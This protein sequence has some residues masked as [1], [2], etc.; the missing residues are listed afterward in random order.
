MHKFM[1]VWVVMGIGACAG[2]AGAET[3]DPHGMLPAGTSIRLP[4]NHPGL[5]VDLAVGLW[6]MPLPM[7]YDKDGDYD[8]V[9]ATVNKPSHGV[10]F[11]ENTQGN[12]PFPV[13]E[14]A[15]RVS[16]AVR[17]MTIS[18]VDGDPV[19][20]VPG[21]AF[22]DFRARQLEHKVELATPGPEVEGNVRAR[23]WK[24][25]DYDG[26]GLLD[27]VVGLGIWAE[28]GWDDAY[29]E[30]GE[31]TNGPLRGHVY[32]CRNTGTNDAPVYA[33]P[34]QVMAG[35]GPVD[36]F[37]APS[38][39]FADF[40]GDGD[41]DL[42]CGEFVDRLTY[43]ENVG[44][45]TEPRYAPG[46]YLQ[47]EGRDIHMDLCMLQVIALD[48][49]KNGH[50]DLIVGEEDGR[51]AWLEHTGAVTD[52]M[53]QFLPPRYFKQKADLLKVGVLN[54]PYSCDWDG[55]GDED[56]IVG[57]TAGYVS[58]VENL[59]GGNP[60]RWAAPVRLTAGGET[61]RIQAGYNG[62]IQGPAEAKWGYTV[63]NVA[64]WNHDGLLDIVINSIWGE[65]LWY[66]NEGAPGA[67]K[68][69]GAQPIAVAWDG[70]APKPEWNWWDPKGNQL[71]T[72]WRTSPVVFDWNGDGLYDLIMLDHE[73][74]LAFFERRRD[75]DDLVLLP[76][77]R[78]FLDEQGEPLH[79]NPGR[80]GK[81]G[82]RKFVLADWDGDGAIDILING[83]SINFMRNIGSMDAPRFTDLGS[84][85]ARP[86]GGHTTCPTTVDWDNDGVPDLLYG[87]EDGF[88]YYLK[89]PRGAL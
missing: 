64:D 72:Q 78:I 63:P 23:Q 86:I 57:D 75:G 47:H 81:S 54:T 46:R 45:R 71:V 22:P 83:D 2:A 33:D 35:D 15:K 48:W 24:L 17:N 12:A 53:P 51:V 65:V 82:R 68:L 62:S 85:D 6:A 14:P 31:W 69:K 80:A 9:V 56:L 8:M 84:L 43:F 67:P 18:Y 30:K 11:F 58:F 4:Y 42:I 59:D 20:L 28:Y 36:T 16:D 70:P 55:D 88:F 32:V 79:L 34:V 3:E 37:G 21:E 7:D 40:D 25:V 19:V 87:A 73:G 50:V 26:D 39:N 60:P 13:F 89:N 61:I 41:L 76:G 38:P 74:Y 29:N 66:E 1:A 10:F 44:T 49:N 5:I 77:K 27:V 52:G